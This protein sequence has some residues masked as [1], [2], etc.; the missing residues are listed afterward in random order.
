MALVVETTTPER[1]EMIAE[2]NSG[3]GFYLTVDE[4]AEGSLD[5]IKC[6]DAQKEV[7]YFE[8]TKPGLYFIVGSEK[9]ID[10]ICNDFPG[11]LMKKEPAG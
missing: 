3:K 5:L 7:I 4:A 6:L 1:R 8:R 9:K 2:S 11:C 10:E